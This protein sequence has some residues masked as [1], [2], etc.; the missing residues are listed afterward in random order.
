MVFFVEIESTVSFYFRSLVSLL[1]ELL[2]SAVFL[3]AADKLSDPVSWKKRQEYGIVLLDFNGFNPL[4]PGV[5]NIYNQGKGRYD[6]KIC[7]HPKA[8]FH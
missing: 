2:A 8:G 5:F 1:R 7:D 3:S 4:V 6:N